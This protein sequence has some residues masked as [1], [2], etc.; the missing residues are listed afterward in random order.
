MTVNLNNLHVLQWYPCLAD[1]TAFSRYSFRHFLVI[2][3]IPTFFVPFGTGFQPAILQPPP[4][5]KWW[6]R[7]RAALTLRRS[8]IS[9]RAELLRPS[10]KG[11]PRT[12]DCIWRRRDSCVA[13]DILPQ[14]VSILQDKSKCKWKST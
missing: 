7:A 1:P 6:P 3:F 2:F 14:A 5:R 11:Q 10:S 12:A 9:I 8:S 13:K 4:P